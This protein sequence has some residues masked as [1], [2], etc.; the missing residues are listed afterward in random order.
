MT[1]TTLGGLHLTGHSEINSDS[2]RAGWSGYRIPVG[3]RFFAPV[4]IGPEAHPASY[5][6]IPD[7]SP[8]VQRPGY[9]VK[10]TPL[11]IAEVKKE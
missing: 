7:H 5:L 3:A 10:H 1:K 6:I 4:H 8:G 11:S 9:G 2:L